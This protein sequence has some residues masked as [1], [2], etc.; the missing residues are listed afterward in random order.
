VP[1]DLFARI[2]ISPASVSV[3]TVADYGPSVLCLNHTGDL[4]PI[5]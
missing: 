5:P 1:L 2:E 3:V 4:P